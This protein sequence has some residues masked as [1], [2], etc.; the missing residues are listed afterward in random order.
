MKA[1]VYLFGMVLGTHSFMLKD[2]FLR[3]DEYSEISEHCFLPGGETGT[4]AAVLSSLG[5]SVIMD[6]NR[7]GAEVGPM[8][9]AFFGGRSVDMSPMTFADDEPGIMDYVI[10]SGDAR[11]PMGFFQQLFS[12]GKRW[13]SIPKKEDMEGCKAAGIDPFFGEESLTAAKLCTELGIPFVTIDCRHDSP[14]H[15]SA[16]VNVVS[17]ECTAQQYPGMTNEEV[18]ALMQPETDGLTIITQGAGDML[19]GRKDGEMHRMKPFRVDV[20]STLGAGDTFKAGCVYGLLRGMEDGELVRFASACSG[21]AISRFPLAL[22]LPTLEEV[23][24]LIN[25]G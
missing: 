19:Y 4:A 15:R 6:G 3:P 16:A 17:H 20:K 7:I 14:L 23:E 12:S 8:L 21:V 22:N 11:T 13:W 9:K 5:A 24:G 25:K 18:F 2:G 10:I 1:D